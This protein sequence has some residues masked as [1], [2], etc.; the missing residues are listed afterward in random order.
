MKTVIILSRWALAVAAGWTACSLQAQ[1]TISA[2][3]TLTE[4]GT[5]GSPPN[6]VYEYSLV[7][8]NTGTVPINAFW[9][10]WI[11]F[12]CDLPSYPSVNSQP[13]DW[14]AAT[15]S[16]STYS[17][18]FGN[19]SGSA[20]MPGDSATFTFACDSDPTAMT[21][22]TNGGGPTGDSVVFNTV[23]AM[24]EGDQSDPGTASEPFIPTLASAVGPTPTVSLTNPAPGAV[25]A[26]PASVNIGATAAVS[27]GIVTNVAFYGNSDLLGTAQAVPFNIATSNLAAG[28]CPDGC[29]DCCRHLR[30]L[31]SGKYFRGYACGRQQLCAAN[32]RRHILIQL[33]RQRWP[34]L[35]SPGL[36][37]PCQLVAA[38]DQCR[39]RQFGSSDGYDSV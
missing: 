30:H 11:Q 29:G 18:Q 4:T 35:C 38:R 5:S 1:G 33:Q 6:T 20:I 34:H 2:S 3:A 7:L 27:N 16:G 39:R 26:A 21:T 23:N 15:L 19:S 8:N 31:R 22:G 9:Y 13:S 12:L 10:G 28:V 37:R 25:F 32:C 17:V 36:F 14:N 24:D